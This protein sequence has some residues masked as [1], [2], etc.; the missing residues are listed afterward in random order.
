MRLYKTLIILIILFLWNCEAK[1]KKYYLGIP[2]AEA[3][4]MLLGLTLQNGMNDSNSGTVIDKYTGLE[5]KKCTQGQSYRNDTNDCQGTSNG[6]LNNPTDPY[7]YGSVAMNYCSLRSNSCNSLGF[8]MMLVSSPTDNA[9]SEIYTS[10]DLDTF[11]GKTD[12]R[13]PNPWELEKITHGG[14]LVNSKIFPNM[15]NDYYWTSYNNET[16][17]TG[18]T[19]IAVSFADDTFGQRKNISK[20]TKLYLRCV[21]NL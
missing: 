18:A 19:A 14:K 9:S 1:P 13:V 7:L 17:S 4:T 2:E 11:N 6:T 15:V 16:D 5:W 10:C 8:P 12:W 3:K 20:D 21:R